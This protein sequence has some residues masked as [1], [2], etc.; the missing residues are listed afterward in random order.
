MIFR[1]RYRNRFTPPWEDFSRPH[2]WQRFGWVHLYQRISIAC[3][4]CGQVRHVFY[5]SLP[6]F[7]SSDPLAWGCARVPLWYRAWLRLTRQTLAR[8]DVNTGHPPWISDRRA[9]RLLR[10]LAKGLGAR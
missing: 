3:L 1:R 9:T 4:S 10:R 8:W 5:E 7:R 6:T 2:H